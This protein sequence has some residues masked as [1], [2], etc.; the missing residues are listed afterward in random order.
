MRLYQGN[1]SQ[2]AYEKTKIKINLKK[3]NNKKIKIFILFSMCVWGG[4]GGG[5]GE[6]E[7]KDSKNQ[8]NQ[9]TLARHKQMSEQPIKSK[10]TYPV[11]SGPPGSGRAL[12]VPSSISL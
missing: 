11:S 4:G 1:Q 9:Q 3:G 7:I 2:D 6:E 8:K 12:P 10:G 5:R